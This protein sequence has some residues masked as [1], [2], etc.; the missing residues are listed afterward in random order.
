MHEQLPILPTA[1][2]GSYP[3]PE[4]MERLKTDC[5]RGRLSSVQ[6]ADIHEMAIK[7]ALRDQELAG[8]DIVSDGELRRDNDIDYFLAKLPG[9][10]IAQRAK[11]FYFDYYDVALDKPLPPQSG[12]EFSWLADDYAFTASHTGKPIKFSFTGPFSLACRITN[13][14]GLDRRALM[15]AIAHRLN[16]AAHALAARGATLLQIDEP[17]LAGQPSEVVDAVAAINV[18]TAG[19]NVS[20]ALHVC[21]GNRYARPLWEGHYDF[22]FPAVLDANVD[23]LVLEF[24]RKGYA[25]LPVIEKFG[26]DRKIGLGVIDVKSQQVETADVVTNRIRAAL[27][28]VP[29]EQLVINPDCGLR[30]L[31]GAVARAKLG[32]MVEGA[33]AARRLVDQTPVV[34]QLPVVTDEVAPDPITQGA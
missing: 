2:V 21:Y 17:F 7:A 13:T 6:L 24:A 31:S 5:L 11:D 14:S 28:L 32:A 22:L 4:W 34:D 19:V 18:V 26:W 1:V 30:N 20:W 8:V 3:V 10:C 12:Q 16:A 23:Q 27:E 33:V 15:E 25:D 29:A 9:L